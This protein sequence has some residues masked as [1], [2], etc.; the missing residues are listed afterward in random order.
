MRRLTADGRWYL[1]AWCR[2]RRAGR[3]F[4][5]DRI[6]TVAAS[7]ERAGSHGLTELLRGSAAAG[8]VPP[9][10]LASLAAA[11]P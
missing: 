11:P 6:T 8:A 5:L 7:T 3:G 2:S 1:I 4:R 10:A 9:A